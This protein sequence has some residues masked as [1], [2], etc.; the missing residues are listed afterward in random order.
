[1]VTK[2]FS[3]AEEYWDENWS[4]ATHQQS[5][6]ESTKLLEKNYPITWENYLS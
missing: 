6:T 2:D 4:C 5:D 1:M 3:G